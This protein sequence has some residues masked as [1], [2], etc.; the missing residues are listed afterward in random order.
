MVKATGAGPWDAPVGGARCDGE[1]HRAER[2]AAP[3]SRRN[4]VRMT[5]SREPIS[6]FFSMSARIELSF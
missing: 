6:P 4:D 3:I 1:I 5:G 2:L